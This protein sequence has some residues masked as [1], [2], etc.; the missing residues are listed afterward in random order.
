MSSYSKYLTVSL[1]LFAGF[2]IVILGMGQYS[3]N[4]AD[5]NGGPPISSNVPTNPNPSFNPNSNFSPGNIPSSVPPTNQAPQNFTSSP[6]PTQNLN[7]PTTTPTSEQPTAVQQQGPPANMQARG[8]INSLIAVPQTKWIAA[9]NWSLDVNH[10]NLSGFVTNMSFFDER[11]VATHTHEFLNLR[12][13][14]TVKVITQ[15]PNS[16]LTIRGVM[17]VGTNHKIVWKNV[18][19][20]ID[21]KGGKTISISVSNKDTNNHFAS[22]PILG[23][24]NTLAAALNVQITPAR[25]T[26][27]EGD[28]QKIDVSVTDSSTGAKIS[29]AKLSGIMI[30]AFPGAKKLIK[31]MNSTEPI[32][33][34]KIEGKKFSGTTDGNGQY[35]VSET[36][37]TGKRAGTYTL[38]VTANAEGY[39]PISEIKTF[40]VEK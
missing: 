19:T 15:L 23:V 33:T 30:D 10:G 26:I 12:P 9:G 38:V 17:D 39:S 11:G 27:S 13:D 40:K 25:E 37:P 4:K 7:S 31:N 8:T 29:G 36:I 5:A 21:L 6:S 24:V 20:V 32:D 34:S 3:L 18:P 2:V 14:P 1:V 28:D 16:T 22:Q 35:S